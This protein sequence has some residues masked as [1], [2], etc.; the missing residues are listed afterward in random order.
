MA[1]QKENIGRHWYVLH[2]Y[3]GQEDR[4]AENLKQRTKSF[5]MEDKVFDILVPREKNIKIKDG[6][7][8]V[9]EEKIYPGYVL[10]EMIVDDKTWYIVRNTAGV[11]GFLGTGIT[12]VPVSLEEMGLLQ[13][14][15]KKQK[16][17]VKTDFDIGTLV[18]ITDGSFK[19]FSGKVTA[20]DAEKGKI[21]VAVDVFGRETP[22][23]LDTL[24]VKKT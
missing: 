11:T 18:E 9:I 12:P 16:P 7:R 23:E 22:V 6:E 2:T 4:V 24:Q 5:K 10:V 8:K 14:K 13:K 15:I 1:Y 20:L 21:S 17:K 3:S 19:N